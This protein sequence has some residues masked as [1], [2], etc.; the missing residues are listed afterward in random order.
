MRRREFCL[1][2]GGGVTMLL[3]AQN[4]WAA[5]STIAVDTHAHTFLHT[6]PMVSDRRYTPDYDADLP[7]YLAMLNREDCTH[8][9]LIQPSF[10]G[11]NNSYL[12]SALAHHPDRLRGIVV[13][14]PET[15]RSTLEDFNKRGIVGIRLNLIGEPD[16]EL[17]SPQWRKHLEDVA[18][19]GWQVEIQAEATRLH[20]FLPILMSVGVTT[21]VDHFGRP[22]KAMGVADPGFKELLRTSASGTIY[23][24]LSGAYRLGEGKRGYEVALQASKSLL[25]AF[26]PERLLW[27]SDWP[28]TEFESVAPDPQ[29]IRKLLDL[30]VP[31]DSARQ[32]I[33]SETPAALFKF[34]VMQTKKQAI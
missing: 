18:Q 21:V 10:L 30:W 27:G 15:P 6:L 23:V 5:R 20:K 34:N 8:G 14:E 12:L 24:K 22:D 13:T 4:A 28:H 33:L 32:M 31:E 25:S 16:P 7:K 26:G 11:T 19:L 2:V 29:H 1:F 9:V 3:S 17:T